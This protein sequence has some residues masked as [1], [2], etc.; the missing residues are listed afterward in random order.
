M[1]TIRIRLLTDSNPSGRV[2]LAGAPHLFGVHLPG[3]SNIMKVVIDGTPEEIR[4]LLQTGD[5]SALAITPELDIERLV[6]E[7]KWVKDNAKK[8]LRYIC[9]H[10]PV[11]GFE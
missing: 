3:G 10:G 1:V 4:A 11:V 2:R 6:V 9:E 8:A 7:L 5:L